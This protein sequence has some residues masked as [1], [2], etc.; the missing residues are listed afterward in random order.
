MV[1]RRCAGLCLDTANACRDRAFRDDRDQTDVS[2]PRDMRAAAKLDRERRA[3]PIGCILAIS[4]PISESHGY[5]A[6]L[7][8]ILLAEQGAGAGLH[9]VIQAHLAGHDGHI[10]EDRLVRGILD[11]REVFDSN[12]FLVR[13]VE[14]QPVRRDER[15][16]LR[17][18]LAE[19]ESQSF[20]EQVRGR[21]I[22]ANG[23][24]PRMVDPAV[25]DNPD[26][27]SARFDRAL[28]DEHIAEPFLR[29]GDENAH[30]VADHDPRVAD[31]TTRFA[32]E[33]RLVEDHGHVVARQRTFH[34]S[35]T[36]E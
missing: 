35:A 26:L 16:F 7:V 36:R 22:G 27:E 8:T 13:E 5:N 31:L 6:N 14:A 4:G 1:A 25:H 3:I 28:V 15:S 19:R 17:D 11:S 23:S 32:V 12:R 30:S 18:V 24:A 2:S 33:G 20:V 9:R 10:V 34:R 29:I 21:M